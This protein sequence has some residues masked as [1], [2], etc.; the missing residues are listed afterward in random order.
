MHRVKELF[1]Y[2]VRMLRL[3]CLTPLSTVFQLHHDSHIYWWKKPEYSEKIT[4]LSHVTD[5]LY[6]I[7]LYRI[8]FA[9]CRIQTHN[10][11]YDI[12]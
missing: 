10:Y 2:R 11:S 12:N 6:H 1:N 8:H 4:D 7:M 3:W 5:K 9:M